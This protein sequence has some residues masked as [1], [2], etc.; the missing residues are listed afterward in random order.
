[1]F[2][3]PTFY[4]MDMTLEQAENALKIDGDLLKGM[5]HVDAMWDRHCD[6][7][8]KYYDGEVDETIYSDDDEFFE[9]WI[10]EVNAYNV[11][12]TEMS[13]LFV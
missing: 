13:K 10:Y 3:I 4:Q 5:E 1:M 2:R 12:F 6:S 9:H 11:V 7:Q 8:R